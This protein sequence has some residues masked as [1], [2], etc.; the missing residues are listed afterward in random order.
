MS[1]RAPSADP[2]G[3]SSEGMRRH[4]VSRLRQELP[5]LDQ[6]GAEAALRAARVWSG[7]P[8][9]ELD[10]YWA[11]R[12]H[13]LIDPGECFP[14]A[15]F[16][17]A[18]VLHAS[19]HPVDV[20]GCTGC[21]ALPERLFLD[22]EG[23]RVCASCKPPRQPRVCARCGRLGVIAARRP[24]G[25]ICHPCYSR[26]PQVVT[27][28]GRCGRLRAPAV[29]RE[30]GTALCQRCWSRPLRRCAGCGT[31][32]VVKVATEEGP[33]CPR[34]YQRRRPRGECEQCGQIAPLAERGS[35][36]R[37]ARCYRC[38]RRPTRHTPCGSCGRERECMHRPDQQWLC[39]DCMPKPKRTC[40][41]CGRTRIVAAN[42]PLGPVCQP[43]YRTLSYLG[44]CCRHCGRARPLI[45]RD[46]AGTG[47]CGPCAG[48]PP[49][50]PCRTCSSGETYI[51][52]QCVRCTLSHRLGERL[53]GPD[54]QPLGQLVPLVDALTASD[55][56]IRLL[57]WLRGSTSARLLGR[58]AAAGRPVTHALLDELPPSHDEC[59]VRALL[60]RTGILPAR[61]EGL[62]RILPWLERLLTAGPA[63]HARLVQPYVHWVVLRKARRRRAR[64]Q[65]VERSGGGMRGEILL[66]LSFLVWLDE[67]KLT[68]RTLRQGHLE[69][70]LVTG[71]NR[72]H[73][74]CT[75]LTWAHRHGLTTEHDITHVRPGSG[76][77]P[78][79]DEQ[80]WEELRVCLTSDALP[81]RVRT[82]RMLTLLYGLP[83]ERIRHLTV[84]DIEHRGQETYLRQRRHALLIPP[85]P[86]RLLTHLAVLA[87]EEA[88]LPATDPTQLWLY[89]GTV[90]GRPLSA[91][92]FGLM[93]RRHGFYVSPARTAA[94]I[95]LAEH[96]P[97]PV[98]AQLLEI[99]IN[100]A[101]KWAAHAQPN[102]TAYLAARDQ[103]GA[104]PQR[105]SP[106]QQ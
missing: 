102:W 44:R 84:A 82:A 19:G 2:V 71:P 33:W 14:L 23:R 28:C 91:A 50:P 85:R 78:L 36:E 88:L 90:P 70:W 42:W 21:G 47:I 77:P 60:V 99:H 13:P 87:P 55:H 62:E 48:Y 74:I 31:V 64:G 39:R 22:D 94:L 63:A 6:D 5:E 54:G 86:A 97:T 59:Y 98:L 95:S 25:G 17:L 45:G 18:R 68:L 83:S 66:I 10:A 1:T 15:L 100:T 53:A 61:E 29:R 79:T 80:R 34:C 89:P 51:H 16:R 35:T 73:D 92:G 106:T 37:P 43:C 41:H 38:Y 40:G 32:D 9:R 81:L 4:L 11:A 69:D 30:D 56:P 3:L 26:D 57:T 65:A 75:F 96:I 103:D 27:S 12:P 52:G 72:R 49:P 58:L 93:M 46:A 104:R 20:P 105:T 8:V 67:R 76:A 7:R 24:E 101:L